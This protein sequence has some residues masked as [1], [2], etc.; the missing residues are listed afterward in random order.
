MRIKNSKKRTLRY[1][2]RCKK[3]RANGIEKNIV[4]KKNPASFASL[5]ILAGWTG[6]EPAT[7]RVTGGRSIQAE[8]P[9]HNK[10][11]KPTFLWPRQLKP[12]RKL[13]PRAGI[14]PATQRLTVVC[15]T[16][17]L[18]RNNFNKENL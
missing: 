16:S 2:L 11:K 13:A 18:P 17:E 12:W 1:F 5:Q 10:K 4:Y 3:L 7:F 15:S 14:E 8:L 9:P 6:L